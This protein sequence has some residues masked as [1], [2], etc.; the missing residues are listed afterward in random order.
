[1]THFELPVCGGFHCELAPN[2]SASWRQT[3]RFLAVVAL[4]SALIAFFSAAMGAWPVAPFAGV[5]VL[6]VAAGLY[7]VARAS[8]RCEQIRVDGTDVVVGS[9]IGVPRQWV[10]FPRA[11]ART[12]FTPAHGH[13]PSRLYIGAAGRYVEVGAFLN[14][15][16]RFELAGQLARSLREG[17]AH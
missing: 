14:E 1:M 2:R 17:A 15:P 6:A 16:E 3:R 10:R 11:F 4:L 13:T 9:G 7:T 5:E 12:R 8:Y